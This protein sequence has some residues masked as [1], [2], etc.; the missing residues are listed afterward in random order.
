MT[1]THDIDVATALSDEIMVMKNGKL[2][3]QG[4]AKTLLNNPTS[5][6]AR[7]LIASAPANWQKNTKADYQSKTLLTVTDLSLARGH[8]DLF[9]GLN[10]EL[11]VGEVL[12]LV[13][14]SGIGK[15]SL[16]DALCG[17]L[18]PKSGK[19]H[20]QQPPKRHQVLKLY[21]DPPSAFASHVSLQTLLNDVID[22]HKLDKNRVP[23]LLKALKLNPDLLNRSALNVSGGEL[24]RIAILRALLFN[25]VL[26]FADEVTNRLD[27]I[28]Q[29]QTMDLLIEQCK[30]CD[31]TLVIVS[32]D[33]H[34]VDYYAD[35]VLDLTQF[36]S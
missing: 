2:L 36:Q 17:L 34:L 20:W 32:H 7:Q 11:K 3:E 13:G 12:G 10:F 22:K 14:D 15:S 21:Q 30:A 24:Q 18:K 5:D 9:R 31:C 27:P 1:I 4:D 28:T 16:G 33:R 8:R 6:Y 26:L 25:P 29:Q 19:I 23:K 35:K